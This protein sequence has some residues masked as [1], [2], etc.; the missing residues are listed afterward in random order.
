MVSSSSWAGNEKE[1]IMG[2]L[3]LWEKMETA[4]L[5]RMLNAHQRFE[6]RNMPREQL[7][8]QPTQQAG[9][10]EPSNSPKSNSHNKNKFW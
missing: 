10:C 2:L 3:R 1:D 9:A 7:Q 6:S 4:A 5:R 8:R